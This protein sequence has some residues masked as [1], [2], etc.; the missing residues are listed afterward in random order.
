MNW[1]ISPA[2]AQTGGA[3]PG[4]GGIEL[5][6]LVVMV[7]VFYFFLIRPQQKRAK[8]H[9]N[10]VQSLNKGDE[11]MTSGGILGRVIKV[12]DDFVVLEIANNL[13]IKLQKQSVQATLPKGTIKSI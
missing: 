4:G 1:L 8:E 12:T 13:E 3:A 9:K 6:M 5:I 11:V 10:L 7:V 2:H